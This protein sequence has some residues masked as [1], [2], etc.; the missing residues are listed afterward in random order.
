MLDLKAYIEFQKGNIPLVL[1]VPHGGKLICDNI[2]KRTR[3]VLGIDG[4]T[5]EI[6]KILVNLIQ[7]YF[8]EKNLEIKSPSYVI[9]KVSR[10]KIDLN[11]NESEAFVQESNIAKHIY[12][13]YHKQIKEII[14]DNLKVYERSILIDL[15]G[16]EKTN[17]PSGFRDVEIVLGTNNLESLFSPK[18]PKNEWG[19]NI[20]GKLVQEFV[21]LDIP[22]APSNPKRNEYV[23]TGGY[24]TKIYGAS[25]IPGSQAIQIELSDKIRIENRDL[26]EKVLDALAK[27]LWEELIRIKKK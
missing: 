17:R 12:R 5:V 27:I 18:I 6:A 10:S 13:F 16:F 20:R 14:L 11:R 24:I 2:P 1:S 25:Q 7:K 22:I 26:R 9:S 19:N 21:K 15:H 23:L 8:K 4:E 3:G